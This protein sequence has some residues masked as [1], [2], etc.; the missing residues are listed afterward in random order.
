MNP[1]DFML[2]PPSVPE[3]KGSTTVH[4]VEIPADEEE[5]EPA[6]VVLAQVRKEPEERIVIKSDTRWA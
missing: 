3:W 2:N 1:I 5:E 6:Q 4:T